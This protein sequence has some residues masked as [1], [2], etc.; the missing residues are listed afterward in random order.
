MF[1]LLDHMISYHRTKMKLMFYT[2]YHTVTLPLLA[3]PHNPM[4]NL[5]NGIIYNNA[6]EH[7]ITLHLK[8]TK[9]RL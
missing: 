9:E 6:K 3:E 8:Q 1:A 2:N 4:P 7:K 5:K